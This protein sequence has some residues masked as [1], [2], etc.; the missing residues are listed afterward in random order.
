MKEY[1][2]DIKDYEGLYQISNL[3]RVKSLSRY[4]YTSNPKFKGYRCTKEKILKSGKTKKGYLIVVLR[5]NNKS[6]SMYVH[7]L[8]ATAFIYN[9]NNL[10]EVNH[11]D[12]N[13][14]NNNVTNLEWCT[15]KYNG[16]YGTI[17][18]RCGNSCNNFKHSTA[19]KQKISEI[20]KK[21]WAKHKIVE[22]L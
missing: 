4:V 10:P 15:H 12:E 5:K 16:N 2:K 18:D 19:T 22:K 7:R 9:P 14:L 11:K 6:K 21:W 1:W 20:K 13:P 17:K 3:G 8:V